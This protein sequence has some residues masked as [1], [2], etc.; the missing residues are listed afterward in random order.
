MR[1]RRSKAFFAGRDFTAI[2]RFEPTC[3]T[4]SVCGIKDGKKPLKIRIWKCKHC[5][6]VLDRDYN[7]AA[8]I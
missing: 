7:A 5:G 1:C 8:T 6:T 3:Q 2:G 4:C